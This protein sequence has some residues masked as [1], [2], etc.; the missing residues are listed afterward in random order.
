MQICD[1]NLQQANKLFAGNMNA[2]SESSFWHTSLKVL[3]YAESGIVACHSFYHCTA[4]LPLLIITPSL[5]IDQIYMPR[6]HKS[7]STPILLLS[8]C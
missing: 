7:Q 8:I 5:H 4:T 3:G 2:E 1:T 6:G